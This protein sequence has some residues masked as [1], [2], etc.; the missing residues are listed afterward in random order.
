MDATPAPTPAAVLVY[1]VQMGVDPA[2]LLDAC[3]P[4]DLRE[5]AGTLAAVVAGML[6]EHGLTE[7]GAEVAGQI[8]QALTAVN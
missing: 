5:I 8:R 4:Q 6:A 1:A 7:P 2:P 3:G